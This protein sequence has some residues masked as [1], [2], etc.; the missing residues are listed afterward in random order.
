MNYA[1]G[2]ALNV[3]DLFRSFDIKRLKLTAKECEELIGNRHKE[4]IVYDVFK[5][6]VKLVLDDI[7]QNSTRFSLPTGAKICIL[8]M[9]R[10]KD[11]QFSQARRSGK[12][13]DVDFL[14]SNF[15]GYQM[16]FNFM[17]RGI[18]REKLVYLDSQN[19]DIITE[20]TNEGRQY[21]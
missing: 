2:Y 17:S 8:G 5:Y 18:M 12:W 16:N 21:Y 15:T 14:A 4:K 19:R 6:A 11:D 13:K 9:K 1:T 7:I 20:Q 10:F 3:K